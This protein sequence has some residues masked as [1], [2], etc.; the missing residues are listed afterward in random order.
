M[1]DL[2]NNF[3]TNTQ[4]TKNTLK[5]DLTTTLLNLETIGCSFCDDD[6]EEMTSDK[7]KL[8][9]VI[10][11]LKNV[12]DM[13]PSA[14]AK[15]DLLLKFLEQLHGKTDEDKQR[16]FIDQFNN[17]LKG[18]A[19]DPNRISLLNADDPGS[20][21]S[22]IAENQYWRSSEYKPC[23]YA[24]NDKVNFSTPV[25]TIRVDVNG[26]HFY[27]KKSGGEIT[28]TPYKN[29]QT[30]IVSGGVGVDITYTLEKAFTCEIGE[31]P[32]IVRNTYEL[33]KILGEDYNEIIL[34]MKTAW[35]KWGRKRL[36]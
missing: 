25:N 5:T 33:K 31:I 20:I 10:D 15:N 2:F 34:I 14:S 27:L 13:L 28:I 9:E 4:A 1:S 21:F 19:L 18:S 35:N 30:N 32:H 24:I 16:K 7:R 26:K 29:S 22:A 17:W 23:H 8:E 3:D 36:Y 11:F 6:D 12:N